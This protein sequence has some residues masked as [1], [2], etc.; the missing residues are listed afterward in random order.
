MSGGQQLVLRLADGGLDVLRGEAGVVDAGDLESGLD[1]AHAVGLVVDGEVPVETEPVGILERSRRTPRL[2][3]VLIQTRLPRQQIV[4]AF[5]H[6]A[7]E[8]CW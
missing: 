8:P 3:K 7:G 5:A 6:L 4:D 1:D 2:W